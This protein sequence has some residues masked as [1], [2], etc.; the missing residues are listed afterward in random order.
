MTVFDELNRFLAVQRVIVSP[1]DKMIRHESYLF[2]MGRRTISDVLWLSDIRKVRGDY[3]PAFSL[4]TGPQIH[5]C[6]PH[7]L[8]LTEHYHFPKFKENI[9]NGNGSVWQF[10]FENR[11][12]SLC[13]L[14]KFV[15]FRIRLRNTPQPSWKHPKSF[16][17]R[18]YQSMLWFQ[19]LTFI[20]N[21]SKLKI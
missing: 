9:Q 11:T 18:Y 14:L 15:C 19:P 4:M 10:Y 16:P 17:F 3:D 20:H 2:A 8:W 6:F 7:C 1:N 13:V 12:C 21:R 5:G